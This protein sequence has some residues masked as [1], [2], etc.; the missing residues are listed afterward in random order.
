MGSELRA[1][2]ASMVGL[3]W[4]VRVGPVPMGAWAV[5]MGWGDRVARS[6]TSRLEREGWVL[7]DSGDGDDGATLDGD[8]RWE[9]PNDRTTGVSEEPCKRGRKDKPCPRELTAI[10]KNLSAR[11]EATLE[12]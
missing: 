11:S 10:R 5:A 9:R 2:P 6:H 12:P 8:G 7:T 4:L 3:E 1:G